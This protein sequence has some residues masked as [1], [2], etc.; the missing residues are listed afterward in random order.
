MRGSNDRVT[1]IRVLKK[2][3]ALMCRYTG[4]STFDRMFAYDSCQQ[5]DLQQVS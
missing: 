1:A 4:R 3:R 5:R 2:E